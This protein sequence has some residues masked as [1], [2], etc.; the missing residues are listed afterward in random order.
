MTGEAIV[1]EAWT[2]SEDFGKRNK[3][4]GAVT[5]EIIKSVLAVEGIPTSARD[6]FV[7]GVPVEIDLIVPR[8][9][10]NP[11]LGG[12]LYEASQVRGRI[13]D[14]E[15]RRPGSHKPRRWRA[16]LF[17][18]VTALRPTRLPTSVGVKRMV[19]PQLLPP[20]SCTPQV[21]L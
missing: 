4:A 2:A 9:G 21:S 18:S 5:L 8:R 1:M 19:I 3:L 10:A 16:G 20:A 14:K 7:K 6:V 12:I 13:G 15:V 11:S 17:T